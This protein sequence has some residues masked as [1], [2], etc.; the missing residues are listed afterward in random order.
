MKIYNRLFLILLSSGLLI[1]SFRDNLAFIA[2]FALIPY[3]VALSKSNFRSSTFL[4]AFTGL[5]FFAG[6]T[7]W[8][9]QYSYAYWFPIIGH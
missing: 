6:I 7:Y 3:F 1:V 4:S 2:W 5:L 9:T 8:F